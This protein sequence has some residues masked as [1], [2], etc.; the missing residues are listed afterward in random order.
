ML[1]GGETKRSGA[2]IFPCPF[3]SEKFD[4]NKLLRQHI[5]EAHRENQAMLSEEQLQ[6]FEA[7]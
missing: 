2:K 4:T 1:N 3:C 5:K 6:V 7:I